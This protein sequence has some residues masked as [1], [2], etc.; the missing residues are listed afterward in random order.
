ML[1]AWVERDGGFP[2]G[3]VG[4]RYKKGSD[5]NT[6]CDPFASSS[7]ADLLPAK[8]TNDDVRVVVGN[9]GKQL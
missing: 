3:G 4:R 6:W 9:N 5:S 1:R 8:A 7:K 2:D